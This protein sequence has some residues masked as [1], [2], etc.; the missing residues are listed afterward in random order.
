MFFLSL[1]V[2]S[3]WN[4]ERQQENVGSSLR[5]DREYLRHTKTNAFTQEGLMKMDR[6]K[7]NKVSLWGKKL[8]KV[9]KN[10]QHDRKKRLI[11]P[12]KMTKQ[13]REGILKKKSLWQIFILFFTEVPLLHT[14]ACSY[15]MLPLQ[16][17]HHM[18]CKQAQCRVTRCHTWT[19]K[20][21]W[22]WKDIWEEN[23]A[24]ELPKRCRVFKEA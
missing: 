9:G 14:G 8:L 11:H 15:T 20:I 19:N 3:A 17:I 1:V 2:L 4:T 13:L 24:A 12:K 16:L 18:I 10:D 5:I 7:R 23:K 22:R 21:V 6:N